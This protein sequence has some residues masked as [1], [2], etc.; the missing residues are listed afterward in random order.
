MS[1]ILPRSRTAGGAAY[2][3]IGEGEP[4]VLL[5]G[6]GMRLEAWSPQVEA[7]SRTHRVICVDLPGHGESERIAPQARLPEFVAWLARLLDDL[8]IAAVNVAGHS[9]GALIAG[10]AAA[11]FG[12]RVRRVALLNG[13]YR[14]GPVAKAAVTER[15]RQI[16]EG[17]PIDF[18]GPLRRWFG[19]ETQAEDAYRLTRGWLTAVDREGYATA[20]R[21][22][23]EGDDVYADDWPRVSCP[24]LFLTGQDDPN[25]TP[26][27]SEAMAAAAPR[28]KAVVIE[29]RHMV[30]LT[31]PEQ[32]NTILVDWLAQEE[33]R[34]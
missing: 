4:L 22:F 8:E 25:S 3:E 1:T 34:A 2:R 21:A 6:V 13:A 20:Y 10:G 30:N 32:V 19:D 18:D 17:A 5:H 11:S 31:A 7:L 23:A 27:M 15:A 16:V 9:M 33:N 24:A 14:R 12:D 26:A 28:G 29:G